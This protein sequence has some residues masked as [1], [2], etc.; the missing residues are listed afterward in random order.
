MDT[1][2]PDLLTDIEVRGAEN[3]GQAISL[4]LYAP[5]YHNVCVEFWRRVA[6]P[7]RPLAARIATGG[8]GLA[9][10]AL[11]RAR[12]HQFHLRPDDLFSIDTCG[13]RIARTSCPT[14]R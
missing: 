5:A 11:R 7:R 13:W 3:C 10:I 2:W 1:K 6:H 9:A 4:I 8:V 12:C 14:T